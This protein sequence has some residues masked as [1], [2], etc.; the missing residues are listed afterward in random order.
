MSNE[1]LVGGFMNEITRITETLAKASALGQKAK[2]VAELQEELLASRSR[3][4]I[5]AI[6][7]TFMIQGRERRLLIHPSDP[8]HDETISLALR[9][10]AS[11][12]ESSMKDISTTVT[13]LK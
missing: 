9:A 6:N 13:P 1:S 7:I 3:N 10:C 5:G 2:I 11:T 12:I 8:A 4:T